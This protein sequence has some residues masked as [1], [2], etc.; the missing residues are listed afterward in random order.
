MKTCGKRRA[1]SVPWREVGL[2]E[3]REVDGGGGDYW[4][5]TCL[6][7]CTL[8]IGP[9]F[10]CFQAGLLSFVRTM[11]AEVN[12]GGGLGQAGSGSLSYHGGNDAVVAVFS[13]KERLD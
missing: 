3:L 9:C 8:Y 5:R 4:L 7:S 1:E 6:V 12:A 11:G 13:F 2:P 10:Y